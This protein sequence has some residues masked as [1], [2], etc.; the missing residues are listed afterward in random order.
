[1][2]E[3][4]KAYFRTRSQVALRAARAAEN[5]I[6]AEIERTREKLRLQEVMRT[7]QFEAKK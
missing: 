4:Q 7:A 2:R 1:M 5:V 3:A 6:D